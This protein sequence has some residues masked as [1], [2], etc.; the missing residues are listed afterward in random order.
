VIETTPTIPTESS[1]TGPAPTGLGPRG[2]PAALGFIYAAIMMN[3]ISMGVIIPVF[4]VLVKTLTGQGDAGG[5]QILGVFGA[6]WALMNLGFAPIFGNLSDRFGRR[7]VLLVAMFGLAFDYLVMALAPNVGWL[8]VGR[9]I[10]GVTASSGSAA[11]AYVA[12]ISSPEDRARNFGRF[13][14]AANA[15]ILLGPVLGGFV[16]ALDPRAPFWIAAL[17]AL[18]NGLYGLFIVPESL[19]HDRRMAFR[20][21]R[22][23]PIGA[24]ALLVSR[25][26]LLGMAL[27]LFVI[28]FAF[29]SF[30]SV[31]QF[32]THYRY[33]WGPRDVAI[34]LVVFSGGGIIM[35]SVVAGWLAKRIGE[36]GSVIFGLASAVGGFAIMGLAP[37][38]A[39]FWGSMAIGVW[40]NVA[41]PSLSSL[42]SQRVEVDQQGQLQGALAILFGL[43]QLAGPLIFSNVFA[44]SVGKGA[45]LHLPGLAL[46]SGSAFIA[47]GVVLSVIYARPPPPKPLSSMS[48]D[49]GAV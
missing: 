29:T 46:L 43:S 49:P 2:R 19:S 45:F 44:W 33:G 12:D 1:S 32:Y 7:P 22:A 17:L 31:F 5:A 15:G 34:M 42:L 26:G 11:G 30:N 21:S 27:V 10:S 9:L 40:S 4:P 47:L 24:A 28:Q 41:F 36:R 8:F 14:A 3:T 25:K 23:N 20:W 16:G 37:T 48:L 35:T 6:A 18:G 38:V 13:Q 39:W